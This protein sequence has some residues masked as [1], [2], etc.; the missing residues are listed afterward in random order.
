MKNAT[1]GAWGREEEEE[2][3]HRAN[4]TSYMTMTSRTQSKM[5]T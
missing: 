4:K 1:P 5:T 2:V 3:V